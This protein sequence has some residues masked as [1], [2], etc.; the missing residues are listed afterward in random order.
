MYAITFDFDTDTL[1]NAYH[2]DS[3]NNAYADVRK[4]LIGEFNF[5]WQQGSVYFGGDSV[6]AVTCVMA[7]QELAD[8]FDWFEA[9]VRDIRMLR[10]DED[11]DLG[12]AIGRASSKKK[13]RAQLSKAA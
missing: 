10:I 6:D 1:K 3:W 4:V 11:N 8:R 2:N 12:P 13:G 5:Q 9:S 7:V